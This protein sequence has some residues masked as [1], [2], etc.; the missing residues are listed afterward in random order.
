MK[1]LCLLLFSLMKKYLKNISKLTRNDLLYISISVMRSYTL[2]TIQYVIFIFK[3]AYIL[4]QPLLK[5]TI[6]T[7]I[8]HYFLPFLLYSNEIWGGGGGCHIRKKIV[9]ILITGLIFFKHLIIYLFWLWMN[10]D[11]DMFLWVLQI[12]Y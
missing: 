5:N 12:L 1:A 7:I 10:Y 8:Y 9:M 11:R 3:L 6:T 2:I 4:I